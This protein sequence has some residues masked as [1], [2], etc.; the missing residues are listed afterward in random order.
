[1]ELGPDQME[2]AC[3]ESTHAKRQRRH[4]SPYEL[5]EVYLKI[6]KI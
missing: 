4:A 2:L 3:S 1:M 5:L 6:L